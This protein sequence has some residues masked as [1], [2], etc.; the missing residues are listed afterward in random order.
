MGQWDM[1]INGYYSDVNAKYVTY[2]DNSQGHFLNDGMHALRNGLAIAQILNRT[3]I[4]PRFQCK[5]YVHCPLNYFILIRKF[6]PNFDYRES[7]FLSHRLVPAN[8]RNSEAIYEVPA[9][10]TATWRSVDDIQILNTL[11]KIESPVI[12]MAE[13]LSNITII[14]TNKEDQIRFDKRVK[15][16]IIPGKYA[17]FW[18][19]TFQSHV[20]LSTHNLLNCFKDYKWY[21]RISNYILDLAWLK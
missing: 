8:I 11:G 14:F 16:G 5:K 12:H 21:I 4:L 9:E 17:Q 7:E 15:N 18:N 1:D 19:T 6:D 20:W 13:A 3:L 10:I 2:R